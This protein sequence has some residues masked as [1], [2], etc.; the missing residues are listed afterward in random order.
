MLDAPG[1]LLSREGCLFLRRGSEETKLLT[2]PTPYHYKYC[3][4][5]DAQKLAIAYWDRDEKKRV[6]C[7]AQDG[8][9]FSRSQ[10]LVKGSLPF[11][12]FLTFSPFSQQLLIVE[13][14]FIWDL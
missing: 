9:R 10:K 14:V 3:F 12:R 13:K 7:L 1:F 6:L 4:S 2:F 11:I 5:R 8:D